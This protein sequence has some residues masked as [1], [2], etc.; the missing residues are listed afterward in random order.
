M[1][2][3][4]GAYMQF[5]DYVLCTVYNKISSDRQSK[6]Y[7]NE[8]KNSASASSSTCMPPEELDQY[9][10]SSKI[11]K[12]DQHRPTEISENLTDRRVM[13]MSNHGNLQNQQEQQQP[14]VQMPETRSSYDYSDFTLNDT[15]M[16][17]APPT[18]GDGFWGHP[19]PFS[20]EAVYNSRCFSTMGTNPGYVDSNG[21]TNM[22]M[23]MGGGSNTSRV[24]MDYSTITTT[25]IPRGFIPLFWM[26]S[27]GDMWRNTSNADMNST[28]NNVN[29]DAYGCWKPFNK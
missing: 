11:R 29:G 16:A 12:I 23:G 25:A 8:S 24:N 27:D 5:D 9:R 7:I 6:R 21:R 19:A 10:P 22:N 17:A 18:E 20:G 1:V 28:T 4:F 13:F 14:I 15:Q 3:L 26:P 2:F